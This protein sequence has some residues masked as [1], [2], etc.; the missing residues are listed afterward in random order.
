M[1]TVQGV[2]QRPAFSQAVVIAGATGL[3]RVVHWVHVGE[4][5][6]IGDF[7]QGN[8]LVLS[9]GVGLTNPRARAQY[10]KGLIR[11]QAAGLVLELGQY[12][13]DVP[14]DMILAADAADL[15][16]I[17]FHH[18]V[19]F[20]DL[21]QEIDSFVI[22][23]H[24]Q[25]LEDLETLSLNIR[26][27]LLNTDGSARLLELLYE[28]VD[29]PIY[30]RPR[31]VHAPPTFFG[32]WAS[33][34]P[35]ASDI[36]LN[37][38]TSST[39]VHQTV[40]VFGAPIAD[41]YVASPG[42]TLEEHLFL[43]LDRVIS[44]LA[45]DYIRT[46][47]L[48]RTHRR[49]DARLLEQLLLDN[50]ATPDVCQR[51][52]AR[53]RITET[54]AMRVCMI[55]PDSSTV[56]NQMRQHL[57]AG[58]TCA[59]LDLQ[60]CTIIVTIGPQ[61]DINHWDPIVD[62]STFRDRG[63]AVGISSLCSDPFY[64]HQ[65]MAEAS[66]AALVARFLKAPVCRY[67]AIGLWRWILSTPHQELKRLLVD[68][69]LGPILFRPD[70]P[71]LLHTLEALFTHVESRQAASVALGIHRQTLYARI[72]HLANLLGEDFLTAPRRLALEASL[73]AY[74]YLNG[75]HDKPISTEN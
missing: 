18:P 33:P 32:T 27:A 61:S 60:E 26:R 1:I 53:Y 7:L 75:D 47:R 30:Y 55:K 44:A 25:L 40:M 50:S 71:R 45:Q 42:P 54:T 13:Q 74:H 65:A 3:H 5:P 58:T 66:D 70:T 16:I 63:I 15:P 73:I 17:A 19:R 41:L 69:E 64:L 72:R 37:P 23:Q 46:E 57:K 12:L 4:I 48:D 62:S 21:S 8:E 6:N 35:L 36:A 22:S 9:T 38:T 20:L 39:C 56:L 34:P 68:P 43:A 28:H 2:L 14:Q 51:F 49:E 52:R 67:D 59:Q 31:A 10:L 11:A 24:H 29:R